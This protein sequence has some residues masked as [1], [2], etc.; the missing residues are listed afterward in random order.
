MPQFNFL[1]LRGR[2]LVAPFIGIVLTL[3]LYFSS[4][5][6][7]RSHGDL[8]Q[9][10]SDSDLPHI[11]QISTLTLL[12]THNHSKF[13]ELLLSSLNDPDEER[14]YIEGKKI[15]EQL[16]TI[17]KK[18]NRE[19][20]T[21]KKVIVNK[22]DLYQQIKIDFKTYKETSISAITL[23]TVEVNRAKQ[24][25]IKTN[26]ILQTLN[27]HF[28]MLSQ[29]YVKKIND[30]SVQVN[31]SLDEQNYIT[32]LTI[33]LILIMVISALYF[34]SSL[35]Q[36]LDHIYQGLIQLSKGN[37][38]VVLVE[39][40]DQYLQDLTNAANSF[41]KTLIQHID[42][43]QQA[44]AANK[45]KS[46]FLASMSHEIRTP[47]AGI[48]GMTELTL[49]SP[50][51]KQQKDWMTVVHSSSKNLLRILN[52]ILE[53]SKLEAGKIEIVPID[54]NLASYI[55]ETCFIHSSVIE[56]KGLEF[57]LSFSEDL[58][59][60]I[61]A[62]KMRLGQIINNLLS[63]AIKF[64]HDGHIH[65]HLSHRQLSTYEFMLF[66]D[67]IDTG[68]GL[69]EQQ[70]CRIFSAF[71]QA[72]NSTSRK[73]GGTGLGLSI[74]RQLASL[75]GG[76]IKVSSKK[77]QGSQFSFSCL[78]QYSQAAIDVS[79]KI[80]SPIWHGARSLNILLV[81]DTLIMQQMMLAIL[82]DIQH[83][84]DL[85]ENGQQAVDKVTLHDYDLILM[86]I[87][88]PIM[89]G[90]EASRIIRAFD[91]EKSQVPIIALTADIA[92]GKTQ[93]YLSNGI[94]SVCGKPIELDLLFPIINTLIGE[95]IHT[96]VGP[97]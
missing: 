4:N 26:H 27:R 90:L 3:I 32:L 50:L 97:N 96:L 57:T 9:Q 30:S 49:K 86:D 22:I 5:A 35:S 18:L 52:E 34:A 47:M 51:N 89:D 72:D 37:T 69:D 6:I 88:M 63:N 19:L 66:I 68:I 95:E 45:T 94:D 65:I 29:H 61:S 60:A 38:S 15:I 83:K 17:E 13:S 74:C 55:K 43:K 71:T 76:E 56:D 1:S 87:R 40:K 82:E 70:Q 36:K 75:M 20:A 80:S 8:F 24:E 85:A 73:Y 77:G 84:V 12:L 58:P 64:T 21:D 41:K 33:L 42:A 59:D 7:I 28:L 93:E 67:V 11:A 54:F 16:H 79:K 62:D 44:E 2:F 25:L 31:A 10:L 46:E 23:T 53:Q 14:L 39:Q 92:A 81:E 78:C 91:S 48:I